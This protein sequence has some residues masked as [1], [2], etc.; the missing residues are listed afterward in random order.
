MHRILRAI[1]TA[2]F[3]LTPSLA[4]AQ[5]API[6]LG[7]LNDQSGVFADYQG[8]GSVIAA[9][10]AVEDFG[11]KVRGRTVEVIS[12]DHQ[13]K[14]DIGLA[15]ARRWFDQENVAAVF[16]LPNSAIALGVN[17]MAAERNKVFVG[18][19]AGTVQLTGPEC[20]AN[21]V[22]WTYDT[23]AYG[24]GI[25]RAVYERGGKKWFFI[26]ADYAFGHDLELQA[27]EEVK[28]LGGQV[29]GAVRHP[30]GNNDYSSYLLQAQASGADVVGIA[31]A[32]GDTVNTIKQAAEFGLTKK[33]KLVGVILGMNNIPGI[34][35][36][37]AQGS[38]MMVP[39]YWDMNDGT[40]AWSKKF[41]ERHPNKNMPNDMQAGVYASVLHYLK[42]IDA[43]ADPAD[44]KAIVAKM[45]ELPTDD[46]LFGKGTIRADGRKIHPMYLL[47]VKAPS[48]SSGKWD[49]L[50][51][52]ASVPGEQA[53]RSLADGK[54]PLAVK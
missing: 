2:A 30:L 35:L 3:A 15:I 29:L 40:R 32:G 46:S 36:E 28:K 11:G 49:Y 17:K 18:S 1:T 47:E 45:K 13:N 42:A 41:Q 8:I 4:F 9:Q 26:T 54:C 23:Y 43:G 44:G 10:M 51:V 14:P 37:A 31:N 12:A 22:H 6:K 24:H 25:G 5:G 53:F 38:Y 20:T 48:E 52:V 39:F 27:T 16:D 7:V 50:K 34:G 33:Q 21:F 19:G